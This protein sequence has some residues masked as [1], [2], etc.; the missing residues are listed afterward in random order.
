M[1]SYVKIN[2]SL[3]F[4]VACGREYIMDNSWTNIAK[5]IENIVNSITKQSIDW[6]DPASQ[7]T[8]NF[9]VKEAI[10]LPRW[11]RLANEEDGLCDEHKNNLI[12]VFEKMETIR[13]YFGEPISVT[14]A[15]RP[16]EYNQLIGGAEISAHMEGMAVDWGIPNMVCDDIRAEIKPKLEEWNIRCEDNAG[17]TWVHIDIRCPEYGRYFVP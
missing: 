11:N 8:A 15:Y 4:V 17:S 10:W 2:I 14:S 7:V 9:S 3:N 13:D 6:T 16:P 5:V 12:S 1:G